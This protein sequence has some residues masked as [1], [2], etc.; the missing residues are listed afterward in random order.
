MS[1]S[2]LVYSSLGWL[3]IVSLAIIRIRGET[4][5]RCLYQWLQSEKQLF[6]LKMTWRQG[7][8]EKVA[9]MYNRE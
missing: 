7:K 6:K 4:G 9:I 3:Q 1:A 5:C 2:L 8:A